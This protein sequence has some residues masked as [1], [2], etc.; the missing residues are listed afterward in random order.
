MTL[1][2]AKGLVFD[3][4]ITMGLEQGRTGNFVAIQDRSHG[5]LQG[6]RKD[7]RLSYAGLTRAMNV[8]HLIRAGWSKNRL[9]TFKDGPSEFVGKLHK[10]M[11]P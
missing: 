3:V 4:V 11:W 8:V 1:H 7:P 2:S 6:T 5:D 10:L 9:G